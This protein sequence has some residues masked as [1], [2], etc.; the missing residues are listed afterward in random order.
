MDEWRSTSGENQKTDS[1][2][3]RAHEVGDQSEDANPGCP[4]SQQLLLPWI[5]FFFLGGGGLK[6]PN[7]ELNLHPCIG[8][9]KS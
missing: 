3:Q 7:Q 2:Q 1:I 9:P 8:N 6:F 4:K 5:F